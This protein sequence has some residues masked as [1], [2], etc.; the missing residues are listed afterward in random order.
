M[1]LNKT[2]LKQ[3]LKTLQQDM[4]TREDDS[5]EHYAEQLATII[6]NYVKTATVSTTVTGTCAT[7][8]GP[9]TIAGNGIGTLT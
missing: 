7:P 1:A 9:G 2:V 8:A 4:K 3:E 5:M 6:D